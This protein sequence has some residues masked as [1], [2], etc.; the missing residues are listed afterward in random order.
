[1]V[2]VVDTGLGGLVQLVEGPGALPGKVL[3]CADTAPT[4]L[5]FWYVFKTFPEVGN[6][7]PEGTK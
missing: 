6:D 4:S 5:Y 3:V 1:M 7:E 2:Q